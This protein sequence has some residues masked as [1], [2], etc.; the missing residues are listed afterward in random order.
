MAP[1]QATQRVSTVPR[2]AVL[3]PAYTPRR[4]ERSNALHVAV[5]AR[6]AFIL[7]QIDGATDIEDLAAVAGV[8]MSDLVRVLTRLADAGAVDLGQR[9]ARISERP[10]AATKTSSPP[11]ASSLPPRKPSAPPRRPSRPI[12]RASTNPARPTVKPPE[13]VKPTVTDD[14]CDLEPALQAR[15]DDMLARFPTATLYDI[16]AVAKDADKK[17]IKRG[18][19][20]LAAVLHPDRHF[21]KRLGPYKAKMHDAFVRITLAYET[22]SDPDKRGAYDRGLPARVSVRAKASAPPAPTRSP[23][24]SAPPL[25][26]SVPPTSPRPD[27]GRREAFA[28]RIVGARAGGPGAERVSVRPSRIPSKRPSKAP[29]DGTSGPSV[30]PLRRFFATKVQESGRERARVFVEAAN[31]ALAKDDLV[32]AAQHYRLALQCCDGPEI[33]S[34]LAAVEGQASARTFERAMREATLAE[35]TER[36]D[37]AAHRYAKAYAAIPGA[38]VAERLANALRNHGADPRRAVKMAEEAVQRE[39]QN[40]AYH[41]TLGEA[42]GDAGLWTRARSEAER[43]LALAPSDPRAK[44]LAARAAKAAKA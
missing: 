20:E 30:D 31:L 2:D 12:R 40:V 24:A 33:R 5:D 6:E 4:I 43:A 28:A 42:C 26:V 7:A 11:K 17:A 23:S 41:C 37:E 16:L 25:T 1:P 3:P 18:Y 34:A 35:K 32:G 22:L 29:S 8:S 15:L 21:R 39:P 9:G 10:R 14:A 44:A 19:Y 27:P 13:E 38:H 36:W